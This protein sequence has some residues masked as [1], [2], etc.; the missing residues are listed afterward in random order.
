M[1]DATKLEGVAVAVGPGAYNSLSV[2]INLAQAIGT[3]YGIP[4]IPVNHIEA[5][6]MT[7][8]MED[9]Q[10]DQPAY[11]E[12]PFLTVIATGKHTEIILTRGVGL[13]TILG[14]SVDIAVGTVLDRAGKE[15]ADYCKSKF[16]LDFE[17]GTD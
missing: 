10:L 16:G 4:V 17:K 6:I 2:G 8:R 13:H 7:T 11:L 9:A 15:L 5:H 3:K 14:F 1:Y 12:F